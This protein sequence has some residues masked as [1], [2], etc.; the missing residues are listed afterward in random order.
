MHGELARST[1]NNGLQYVG[2]KPFLEWKY[3]L[4]I[5]GFAAPYHNARVWN[6]DTF[7][8]LCDSDY[9]KILENTPSLAMRCD[10]SVRLD[11]PRL[12]REAYSRPAW[13]NFGARA[14]GLMRKT[15]L[16]RRNLSV[17]ERL[18]TSHCILS[19]TQ[20]DGA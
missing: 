4:E 3:S 13:N 18:P 16:E 7:D 20:P 8:A 2:T 15:Q 5:S 9:M 12:C 6:C 10:S 14:S 19:D 17:G 1:L 11:N